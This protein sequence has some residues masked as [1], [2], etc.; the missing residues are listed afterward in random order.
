[1]RGRT[2]EESQGEEVAA[3][4]HEGTTERYKAPSSKKASQPDGCAYAE[5][6]HT[7]WD[8]EKAVPVP[9][10][11]AHVTPQVQA[12]IE[13]ML[14]L[15][16]YVRTRNALVVRHALVGSRRAMTGPSHTPT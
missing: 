12:F 15:A 13:P 4:L 8:L 5:L 10:M 11:W 14:R 3:G 6:Y 1:M 16:Y 7:G 9:C 2:E